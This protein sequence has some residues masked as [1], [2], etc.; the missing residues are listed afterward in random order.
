MALRPF[1]LATLIVSALTREPLVPQQPP[2]APEPAFEIVSVKAHLNDADPEGIT[3]QP[4]GV[5]FTGFRVRT[6]IMMAY[7]SPDLQRF[8]QLVG[9]PS[10][11]AAD[12]FDVVGKVGAKGAAQ[13]ALPAHCGHCCGIAFTCS[14]TPTRATCPRSRCASRE[15]I[16]GSAPNSVS[17]RSSARRTMRNGGA[18]FEPSA[19]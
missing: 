13:S 9:G 6:L 15:R 11:I 2:D 17:R 14:F 18:G 19:A 5:R 3:L 1:L 4:D 16:A 10:W 8:D 7:R 12:R